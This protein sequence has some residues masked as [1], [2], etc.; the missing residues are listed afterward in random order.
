MEGYDALSP[1][2]RASFPSLGGTAS[3]TDRLLP[4]RTDALGWRPG[5]LISRCPTGIG[6]RRSQGSPRFLGG[7]DCVHALGSH[8]PGDPRCQA[9]SAPRMLPSAGATTSAPRPDLSRLITTACTLAVYASRRQVTLTR[10]KTRFRWGANPC[11][12]GL[13]PTGSTTKGFRFCLLH[14]PSSLPRLCLAQG[15]SFPPSPCRW[16]RGRDLH[17]DPSRISR[18]PAAGRRSDRSSSPDG[19]CS[20]AALEDRGPVE[21]IHARVL[22]IYRQVRSVPVFCG[23]CMQDS[24]AEAPWIS[25]LETIDTAAESCYGRD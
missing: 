13:E 5:L 22:P 18:S 12:V 21:L 15:T 10:R 3:A 24:C 16:A 17:R 7:P 4:Q 25:S 2:R 19:S 14:L 11:R 9:L 1:S 8:T 6:S 23:P 20:S